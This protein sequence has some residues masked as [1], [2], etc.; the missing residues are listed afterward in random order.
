MKALKWLKQ[1]KDID[2]VMDFIM[3]DEKLRNKHVIP[4]DFNHLI[5]R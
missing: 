2:G 5:A 4:D 1:Y 3:N